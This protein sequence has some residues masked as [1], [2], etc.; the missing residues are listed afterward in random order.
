[1][2]EITFNGDE[3]LPSLPIEW[4]VD[5]NPPKGAAKAL[6]SGMGDNLDRAIAQRVRVGGQGRLD[7]RVAWD[8]EAGYDYGYVQVS[9]D[10]GETYRSVRCTDSIDGPFGP[11]FEGNSRGFVD[12]RCNLSRYAGDRVILAFRYVTDGGVAFDG[13]WVDEVVLDGREIT[14]GNSLRG[15]DSPTQINPHDVGR[16]V[17]TLVSRSDGP[18]PSDFI[19][20]HELVLDE[21]WDGSLSGAEL[22]AA[23]GTTGDLVAAVVTVLDRSEQIL[24]TAA[25]TLTVNGVVQPGGGQQVDG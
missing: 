3:T 13:F 11:A 12:Q 15:W 9:D 21:S 5:N 23:I 6:Y 2:N 17:V 24:Q 19:M 1:V 4:T 22:D 18:G 16:W 14:S 10:G 20:V 25:Y 7:L 8:T